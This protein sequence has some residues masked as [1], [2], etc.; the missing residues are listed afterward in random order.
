MVPASLHDDILRR[1]HEGHLGIMKCQERAKEAVWW[2]GINA[3]MK[4]VVED[5]K[6]CQEKR[7]SQTKEPLIPSELPQRAFQKCSIDLCELKG[8]SYLVLVDYYSR[9]IELAHLL[10]ITTVE[11]IK[12]MKDMFA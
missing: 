3:R 12:N 4:K 11:V 8:Q 2:P 1:I 10:T 9:Y 5:C 7:S 6:H